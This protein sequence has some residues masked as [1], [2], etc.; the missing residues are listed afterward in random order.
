MSK[1]TKYLKKEAS[2]NWVFN[3]RISDAVAGRL[4]MS[5]NNYQRSLQT[6]SLREA[7]ALRYQHLHYLKKLEDAEALNPS[8]Q[9]VM[10][11]YKMM[12]ADRISHEYDLLHNELTTTYA[13]LGHPDW[14]AMPKEE[15]EASGLPTQVSDADDIRYSVLASLS[16]RNPKFKPPEKYRLKLTTALEKHL[17]ELGD[18]NKKTLG[19]YK[20][21]IRVFL[22]YLNVKD[23]LVFKID[24]MTVRNFIT[25]CTSKDVEGDQLYADATISN[26]L[27]NL[28]GVWDYVRDAEDLNE[29]NPF[30]G[31]R[32][33]KKVSKKKRGKQSSYDLWDP[34]DLHK[35][36]A[37]LKKGTH[38]D[39]DVLPVYIAWYTGARVNEAYDVKPEDIKRCPTSD[40]PY[41]TFKEDFDGKSEAITRDVPIH[42]ELEK[43]LQGFTGFPRTS[44]NAYGKAFGRAKRRVGFNTRKLAFHSIRRNATTS[45]DQAGMDGHIMNQIIGHKATQGG[46]QFGQSYYSGGSGFPRLYEAVK[47]I[48]KL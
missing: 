28:G 12:E 16:G 4:G 8:Y 41:I 13:H 21:S 31:H 38:G 35:V 15:K 34:K 27:S 25:Q 10:D 14:E 2:G 45:L 37:E 48:P 7:Q 30:R 17:E 1:D 23:V 24:R 39:L 44:H 11:E 36:I 20:N 6:D 5:G 33:A 47:T 26:M 29:G 46:I 9:Q 19:K 32:I 40:I 22:A 43:L 18:L 42:P 3:K